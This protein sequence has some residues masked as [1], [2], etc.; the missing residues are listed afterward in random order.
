MIHETLKTTWL[1][2][3][4]ERARHPFIL[5]PSCTWSSESCLVLVTF[6]NP[7]LMKSRLQVQFG[8]HTRTPRP[9]NQIRGHWR[10][11]SVPQSLSIELVIVNTQTQFAILLQSKQDWRCIQSHTLPNDTS[12]QKRRDL[13]FQLGQL[14]RRDWVRTSRNRTQPR[15]LCDIHIQFASWGHPVA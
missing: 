4:A 14:L 9:C 7:Q 5:C 3:Q 8:K 11:E 13:S 12:L 10:W 1:V 6:T 2:G 15:S